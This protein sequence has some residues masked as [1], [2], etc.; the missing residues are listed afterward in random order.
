MDYISANT[1]QVQSIFLI[2][3]LS[4]IY[5]IYGQAN[6]IWYTPVVF[7]LVIYILIVTWFYLYNTP[8]FSFWLSWFVDL[9]LLVSGVVRKRQENAQLV[10]NNIWNHLSEK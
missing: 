6:F 4:K 2:W 10:R 9:F 1:W 5:D 8:V 3:K 7:H